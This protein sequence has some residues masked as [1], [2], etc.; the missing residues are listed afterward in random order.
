MSI[1]SSDSA[2]A[3]FS[4]GGHSFTFAT[5]CGLLASGKQ[6]LR[7]TGST[8]PTTHDY[9]C[10]SLV[11]SPVPAV[12]TTPTNAGFPAGWTGAT[13]LIRTRCSGAEYYHDGSASSFASTVTCSNYGLFK[14]GDTSVAVYIQYNGPGV[15]TGLQTPTISSGW[16]PVFSDSTKRVW[17]WIR[18]NGTTGAAPVIT[19][20]NAATCQQLF[21]HVIRTY[22]GASAQNYL[23]KM[24][25]PAATALSSGNCI[26]TGHDSIVYAFFNQHRAAA[27]TAAIA[28]FTSPT[29][30]FAID[31]TWQQVIFDSASGFFFKLTSQILGFVP[32]PAGTYHCNVTSAV[33]V[34]WDSG[35]FAIHH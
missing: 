22:P 19:G 28:P 32:Q 5:I 6:G 17:V 31:R 12:W 1:G 26:L 13:V 21:F 27:G 10:T 3:T 7:I 8:S 25:Q 30:P 24:T 9:P 18:A 29:S 11:T 14:N 35:I 4:V 20:V 15:S 23:G 16:S 2:T 34:E 33:S